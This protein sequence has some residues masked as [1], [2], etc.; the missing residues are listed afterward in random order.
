[1]GDL[2]HLQDKMR[3]S[4]SG[5][6]VSENAIF[7]QDTPDGQAKLLAMQKELFAFRENHN[8]LNYRPSLSAALIITAPSQLLNVALGAVLTKFG[9]Y[10]GLVYTGRLPTIQSHHSALAALTVYV[11]SVASGLFL[12]YV[13]ML[14][15]LVAI[16][17]GGT[18]IDLE[19]LI[20][21]L[22]RE[23]M[24]RNREM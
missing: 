3:S 10:F 4:K 12:F 17:R 23:S 1:M 16:I 7:V 20:T 9:I 11:A 14:F 2:F 21:Y 8:K 24:P 5:V 13:L 22:E 6:P 18:R 19:G 15:K